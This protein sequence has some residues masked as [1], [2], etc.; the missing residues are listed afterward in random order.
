M[1][2]DYLAIGLALILSFSLMGLPST[3]KTSIAQ[4]CRGAFWSAGQ[5]L[6]SRVIRYATSEQKTRVLLSQNVELALDN[7]SLK[8][9]SWENRRLRH[10]LRFKQREELKQ[11]IPAEVIG[12]DPD[13]LYDTIVIN[14]GR[15]RAIREDWPVVTT[16]GLVGHVTQ[17]EG[18][19]AV[20][21][22]I[23]RS[24]ISALVQQ[25]RAQG[26]VSWVS[27]RSFQLRYVDASSDIQE[28]D[29]VITSGLGGRYPKGITIGYVSQVRE[30]KRNPLFKEIIIESS[31]DFWDLEEVFVIQ[32]AAML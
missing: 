17:V 2:R 10:A 19:S 29:R 24:R 16:E 3:Q 28:K 13:Q 32:P 4:S 23:M 15:D 31:V 27:G 26:I 6:F 5:W 7:M 9:A 11:I 25:E 12:R 30:Q 20:V 18:T 14:A 21:Q 22:L 1:N 8:E